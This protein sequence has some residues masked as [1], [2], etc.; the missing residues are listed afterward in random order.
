MQKKIDLLQKGDQHLFGK[1]FKSHAVETE[2]SKKKTLDV[3]S[4]KKIVALLLQPKSSFGR[5]LH[6]TAISRKVEGHFTTVKNRTIETDT[7]INMAG[8]KANNRAVVSQV[9][10]VLGQKLAI[11]SRNFPELIPE[12]SLTNVYRKNSK[13][14]NWD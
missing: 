3:F 9:S 11:L 13:P 1:K 7:T 2:C 6:P 10:N 4:N 5:A 14:R 12:E 8:N